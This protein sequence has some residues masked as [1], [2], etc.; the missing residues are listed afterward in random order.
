MYLQTEATAPTS[1]RE[2][3]LL[4]AERSDDELLGY[5]VPAEWLSDVGLQPR[6]VCWFWPITRPSACVWFCRDQADRLLSPVVTD[7]DG[8]SDDRTGTV[9]VFNGPPPIIQSFKTEDD[10][11][12]AVSTWIAANVKIGVAPHDWRRT[13][14]AEAIIAR[15]FAL[16]AVGP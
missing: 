12:A 2:M 6:T 16:S 8:Y 10:E 11:I 5:G 4:F 3:K 7:M 1:P 14:G 9:S 13:P 15:A